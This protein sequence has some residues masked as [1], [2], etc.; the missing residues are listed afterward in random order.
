MTVRIQRDPAHTPYQLTEIRISPQIQGQHQGVDEETD[1]P[2]KLHVRPP[3]HRRS[4]ADLR[5]PRQS[6]QQRA[7]ARQQDHERCRP[8]PLS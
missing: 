2:L 6:T 5:L 3:R 7:E 8:L 4:N 1:Q